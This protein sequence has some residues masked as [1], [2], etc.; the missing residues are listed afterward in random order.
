[1]NIVHQNYVM[2]LFDVTYFFKLNL[3]R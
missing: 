3:A 2:Q 1:M